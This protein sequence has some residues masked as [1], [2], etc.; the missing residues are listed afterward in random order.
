MA[1]EFAES[2]LTAR[3]EVSQAPSSFGTA[4]S[5]D[6]IGERRAESSDGRA[7]CAP[8][9]AVLIPT[10]RRPAYLERCLRAVL[11]QTYRP[12][13]VVVVVREEDEESKAVVHRFQAEAHGRRATDA[14]SP[15]LRA[16]SSEHSQ[17]LRGSGVEI[18][19]VSVAR[20]GPVWAFKRG[21]EVLR[22]RTDIDLVF[23]TDD[24]AAAEPEWI[25]RGSRH[26][27]DPTVGIV[28]GRLIPYRD[29]CPVISPPVKRV[30]QL[31]WYGRYAGGFDRAGDTRGPAPVAGFQGCNVAIRRALLEHIE[32][33]TRVVGYGIQFELDLA[34]QVRRLGYRILFD[35]ECRVHHFE[36]PRP[37]PEEARED[38]A[39]LIYAYSHNH[40]Y[41]MLK[42]LPLL[43]KLAFL[44]YF[45]VRGERR[46]LGL[47]T[48]FWAIVRSPRS[49]WREE[50]RAAFVG[51]W[52]GIRTY[53]RW[54]K[55]AR[56]RG[57]CCG[58]PLI[59]DS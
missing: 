23:V 39:R 12:H 26:F 22:A 52:H 57:R 30:G 3:T 10:Y 37:V 43:Q 58:R 48:L 53:W 42:H 7:R 9:V 49:S 50:A 4:R 28:A 2:H 29:G 6:A 17:R 27:S 31:T 40:T 44:L 16:H 55:I 34:L 15:N 8:R 45:F 33:D 59:T 19:M 35:P 11:H 32:V 54:R 38:L 20:P 56:N 36:A 24:D 51:K 46:S 13:S 47:A 21:I 14:A 5:C 41:L 18:Q 25:E 1:V